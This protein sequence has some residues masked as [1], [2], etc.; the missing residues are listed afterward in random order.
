M[1]RT[2]SSITSQL[3]KPAQ[4]SAHWKKKPSL[5][6]PKVCA[7]VLPKCLANECLESNQGQKACL[8]FLF[9]TIAALSASFI[10]NGFKSRVG[11]VLYQR[12]GKGEFSGGMWVKGLA[13]SLQWLGL[14]LWHRFNPWPG[15]NERKE[16]RKEGW[17]GGRDKGSQN[18]NYT[19]WRI[20]FYNS[21]SKQEALNSARGWKRYWTDRLRH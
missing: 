11:W 14:L 10:R 5:Q 16:G 4:R 20:I 15:R 8:Y 6:P 12:R 9:K 1:P 7:S 13:L 18:P 21:N 3:W 19:L 2:F 17:E